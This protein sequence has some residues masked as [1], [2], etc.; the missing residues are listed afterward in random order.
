M[1]KT[2]V[3]N[4]SLKP[5]CGSGRENFGIC[6]WTSLTCMSFVNLGNTILYPIVLKVCISAKLGS[7][8]ESFSASKNYPMDVI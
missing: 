3:C 2:R 5:V 8:N 4:L 1:S 6:R 7:C